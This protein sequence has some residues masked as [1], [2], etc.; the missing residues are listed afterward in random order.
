MNLPSYDWMKWQ[1]AHKRIEISFAFT[2]GI[3]KNVKS[4]LKAAKKNV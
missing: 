4:T 3:Q 1:P 2:E